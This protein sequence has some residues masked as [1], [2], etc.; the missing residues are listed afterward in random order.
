MHLQAGTLGKRCA[1][2]HGWLG[3][4][5]QGSQFAEGLHWQIKM[6]EAPARW[7]QKAQVE[8]SQRQQ[9]IHCQVCEP[10]AV[11]FALLLGL[12]ETYSL[13]LSCRKFDLGNRR[14]LRNQVLQVHDI[15]KHRWYCRTSRLLRATPLTAASGTRVPSPLAVPEEKLCRR[16]HGGRPNCRRSPG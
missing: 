16:Y 2:L 12:E 5:K 11:L 3:R 7:R 15:T 1:W 9:Q 10:A 13:N 14:T 4:W 6:Y 8:F